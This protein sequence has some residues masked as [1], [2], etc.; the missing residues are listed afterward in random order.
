MMLASAFGLAAYGNAVFGGVFPNLGIVIPQPPSSRFFVVIDSGIVKAAPRT[1]TPAEVKSYGF[2]LSQTLNL[3]KIIS[4]L[5]TVSGGNVSVEAASFTDKCTLVL[6]SGGSIDQ[7]CTVTNA[8]RTQDGE[9]FEA[10]FRLVV[11]QY[12]YVGG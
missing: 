6:L 8:I 1:K 12:N 10:S 5:W 9:E 11:Q 4:S 3:D 2:D 7:S